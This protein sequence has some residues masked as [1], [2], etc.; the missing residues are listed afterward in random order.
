[1][2]NQKTNRGERDV[3]RIEFEIKGGKSYAIEIDFEGLR[4]MY[5]GVD[6]EER[7]FTEI[8]GSFVMR[9]LVESGFHSDV[10]DHLIGF[11]EKSFIEKQCKKESSIT[12]E[13]EHIVFQRMTCGRF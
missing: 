6:L 9:Y 11:D 2:K 10:V 4:Q 7:V 8:V 5:C 1:M 13:P 3:R 12:G